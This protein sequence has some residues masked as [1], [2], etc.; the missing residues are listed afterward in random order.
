L[1]FGHGWSWISASARWDRRRPFL[2]LESL[3]FGCA[4]G[5]EFYRMWRFAPG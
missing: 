1:Q 5:G 3:T 2:D 4:I